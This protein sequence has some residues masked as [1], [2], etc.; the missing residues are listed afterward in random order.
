VVAVRDD[1][2]SLIVE[3]KWLQSDNA[4]AVVSYVRFAVR[5]KHP[6]LRKGGAASRPALSKCLSH[7]LTRKLAPSPKAAKRGAKDKNAEALAAVL[8]DVAGLCVDARVQSQPE[9]RAFAGF[10][11]AAL[12]AAS[13]ASAAGGAA[14][15]AAGATG[16]RPTKG[17]A[18]DDN[19]DDDDDDGIVVEETKKGK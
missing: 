9:L 14:G 10:V 7:A 4:P 16:K 18:R 5:D 8:K 17:A 11:G 6:H 1:V 13:A 3:Q 2:D 19:D 12:P 15:A